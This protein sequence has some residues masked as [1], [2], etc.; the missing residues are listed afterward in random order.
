MT[1]NQTPTTTTTTPTIMTD[2]EYLED[3][4][5]FVKA[6][7][8][9]WGICSECGGEVGHKINCSKGIAFSK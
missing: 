1:T 6:M 3:C 8:D 7:E 4:E 9:V 5:M 2:E